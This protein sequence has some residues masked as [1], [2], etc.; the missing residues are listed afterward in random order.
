MMT[1]CSNL[2]ACERCGEVEQTLA[3]LADLKKQEDIVPDSYIFNIAMIACSK[4]V[5]ECFKSVFRWMV[6]AGVASCALRA[7]VLIIHALRTY[8][9]WSR[10]IDLDCCS[11]PSGRGGW[12]TFSGFCKKCEKCQPAAGLTSPIT[13][14]RLALVLVRGETRLL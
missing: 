2:T 12:M 13:T 1:S 9:S 14:S 11:D 8:C 4:A 7:D 6:F 10:S 5:S 3:L